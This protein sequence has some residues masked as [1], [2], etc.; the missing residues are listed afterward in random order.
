MSVSGHLLQCSVLLQPKFNFEN[1]SLQRWLGNKWQ[2]CHSILSNN[3]GQCGNKT[4]L[5]FGFRFFSGKGKIGISL[6]VDAKYQ[7]W[8][9]RPAE[10]QA[11]PPRPAKSRPCTA[12]QNWRNPRGAAGQKGTADSIDTPFHY[13]RVWWYLKVK[14]RKSR[15][16]F[17]FSLFTYFDCLLHRNTF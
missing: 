17:Y 2:K 12:P 7:G 11:A 1:V 14:G 13:A 16:I 3:T 15:K 5:T 4:N 8:T 9:P 6:F 10:K